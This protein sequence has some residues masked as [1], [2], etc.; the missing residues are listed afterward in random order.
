MV[1]AP[2]IAEIPKFKNLAPH[3]PIEL[4]PG[5]TQLGT[6]C[7]K[8]GYDVVA[9]VIWINKSLTSQFVTCSGGQDN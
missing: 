8:D 2:V 4:N 5:K 1:P 9:V 3:V 6:L 7:E